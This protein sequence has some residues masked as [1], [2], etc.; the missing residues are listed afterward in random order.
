MGLP[1][2]LAAGDSAAFESLFR[3]GQNPYLKSS[4][5]GVS[6]DRAAFRFR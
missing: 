3:Q 4:Q 5:R 2:R 6:L 1:Q